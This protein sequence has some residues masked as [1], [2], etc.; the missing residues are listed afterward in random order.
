MQRRRM[1]IALEFWTMMGYEYKDRHRASAGSGTDGAASSPPGWPCPLWIYPDQVRFLHKLST[2]SWIVPA[3]LAI[4]SLA[5]IGFEQMVMHG[6][7][8]GSPQVLRG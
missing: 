7:P 1:S 5:Y 8:L 3:C 4:L 6:Y 2:P